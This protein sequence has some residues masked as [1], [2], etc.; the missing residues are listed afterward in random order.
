MKN[1]NKQHIKRINPI[2]AG[3]IFG[4]I[5]AVFG[6]FLGIIVAL[7][8]YTKWYPINDES[9]KLL[10]PFSIIVLPIIYGVAGFVAGIFSS[11]LY[12]LAAKHFGGIELEIE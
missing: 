10:G 2:S 8:E 3:R 1:K 6:F 11:W 5:Y 4:I 7:N 12:N 9:I